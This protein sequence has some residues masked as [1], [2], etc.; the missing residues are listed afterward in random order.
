M[1]RGRKVLGD[2]EK[3]TGSVQ[4]K[5]EVMSPFFPSTMWALRTKIKSPGL[6]ADSISRQVV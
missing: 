1:G 4:G 2:R 3:N 6:P 5:G